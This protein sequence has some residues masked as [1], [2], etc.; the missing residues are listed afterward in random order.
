M[1][2]SKPSFSGGLDHRL[3]SAMAFGFDDEGGER[4]VL[5]SRRLGQRMIGRN[6]HEFGAEQR[7]MPRRED[8]ELGFAVGRGFRIEREPDQEPLGAPDP[9]AL[10][11]A[12]LLGPA[13]ERIERVEQLLRILRDLEDPLVHFALL[14]RGAGAPAA[15]VDH[16]LVGEH[17]HVDRVPVHLALLALGETRARKSRNI[18]CWCL[19]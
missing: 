1:P 14:D 16:L 7:V 17:G 8:F 15:T 5:L 13:V 2:V 3:G 10:H 18:F 11:R 19:E 6:R 12:H 9:V 4:G